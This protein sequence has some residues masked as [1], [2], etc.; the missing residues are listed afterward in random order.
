M[1]ELEVRRVVPAQVRFIAG[2]VLWGPDERR[3]VLA[4]ISASVLLTLGVAMGALGGW[5]GRLLTG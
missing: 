4:S 5:L 2:P 3:A 1:P